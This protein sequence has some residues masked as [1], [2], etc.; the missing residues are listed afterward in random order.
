E[1]P[2]GGVHALSG[3][4][5]SGLVW[6]A[7]RCDWLPAATDWLAGLRATATATAPRAGLTHSSACPVAMRRTTHMNNYKPS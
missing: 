4:V 5:W 7:A 1:R 3:L 6:S 2:R